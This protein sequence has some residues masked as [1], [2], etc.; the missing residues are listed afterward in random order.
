MLSRNAVIYTFIAVFTLIGMDQFTK[1]W[2][3]KTLLVH[4]DVSDTRLYRG[5]RQ[6]IVEFGEPENLETG[7][8]FSLQ[9]N[10]V[11]NHG[12]AWGILSSLTESQRS[13]IFQRGTLALC[14]FL[15][16]LAFQRR[17]RIPRLTRVSILIIVGGAFSNLIDR[18]IHGYVV[19][20][21]DLRL[22]WQTWRYVLPAFNGADVLIVLGLIMA[23]VAEFRGMDRKQ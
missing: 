23:T 8:F 21:L 7:N 6:P 16:Y 5:S 9:W 18:F 12:A 20:V 3:A 22:Q 15:A 2:G 1:Y 19:D 10:Y 11:R 4:A 14:C 17:W 13:M